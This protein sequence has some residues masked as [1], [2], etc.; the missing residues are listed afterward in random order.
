METTENT[1]TPAPVKT[2]KPRSDKGKPKTSAL[3]SS[4][5]GVSATWQ[6]HTA[7]TRV[8]VMESLSPA[9][10]AVMHA[11]VQV[12]H[13]DLRREANTRLAA[14]KSVAGVD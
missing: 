14:L 4:I 9:D 5:R 1:P 2:K 12:L 3:A 13:A 6:S 7:E 10:L 11:F 8:L